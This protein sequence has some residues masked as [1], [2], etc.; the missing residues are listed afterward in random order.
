MEK[1]DRFFVA[2]KMNYIKGDNRPKVECILCSIVENDP[3]VDI[4]DLYRGENFIIT[5]NLYP[6]NPGHLLIFPKRHIETI[7]PFTKEEILE[8]HELELLSFE[9]LT[10]EYNTT[11]FNI[12]YNIGYASGA[13]IKHLHMHIVP[14]YE[15][16]LGFA[17]IISG[18]K[19][20][21]EDPRNTLKRLRKAFDEKA[22]E[23]Q[24]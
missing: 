10:K 5:L 16:E 11:S 23:K 19:V 22:L 20:I 14:R 15:R 7:T 4:L 21:A 24:S 8:L 1:L 3:Q 13:S 17:E 9:V 18:T 6:Y 12:G 2:N